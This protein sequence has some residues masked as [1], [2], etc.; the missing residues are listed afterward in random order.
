MAEQ[1]FKKGEIVWKCISYPRNIWRLS[2]ITHVQK[3]VNSSW[4]KYDVSIPGKTTSSTCYGYRSE[5][6]KLNVTGQLPLNTKFL[7]STRLDE[8]IA[9]RI[10][11]GD[12]RFQVYE[13][14]TKG[15]SK[16]D[17]LGYVIIP[18]RIT[19]DLSNRPDYKTWTCGP[20]VYELFNFLSAKMPEI[21]TT[22]Y[23]LAQPL[24][25]EQPNGEEVAV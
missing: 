18:H 17:L 12:I 4:C 7:V 1:E 3:G 15:L 9:T 5:L 2:E 6:A 11:K 22:Y 10:G 23:K 25:T 20:S 14:A 16:G 19:E 8:V 13:C 21:I 24:S